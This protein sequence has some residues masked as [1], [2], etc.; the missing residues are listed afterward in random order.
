MFTKFDDQ[1]LDDYINTINNSLQKVHL[2]IQVVVHP[3]TRTVYYGIIN[4]VDD[5]ISKLATNFSPKEIAY[6][7]KIVIISS[8]L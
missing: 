5:D 2:K 1:T 8:V 4:E 7:K 3:K 6:F